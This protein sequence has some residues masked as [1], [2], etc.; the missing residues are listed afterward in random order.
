M[1]PG[2]S[3]AK[4]HSLS[5]CC[6]RPVLPGKGKGDPCLLSAAATLA[7]WGG[8]RAPHHLPRTRLQSPP[9]LC[10]SKPHCAPS[11]FHNAPARSTRSTRAG[12]APSDADRGEGGG[13][14]RR[15]ESRPRGRRWQRFQPNH[16]KFGTFAQIQ[17]PDLCRCFSTPTINAPKQL[18]AH[19]SS[20]LTGSERCAVLATRISPRPPSALQLKIPEYPSGLP[21]ESRGIS[22]T[23]KTGGLLKLAP[24]STP[25]RHQ[26]HLPEPP[27]RGGP[28]QAKGE[29]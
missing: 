17:S 22:R 3:S 24:V 11:S 1:A 2:S 7:S 4:L 21:L 23:S 28:T 12:D 20:D 15:A 14:P 29:A 9:F 6:C 5:K 8:Q 16:H 10:I 26:G 27:P 13:E 18:H 25:L 19:S